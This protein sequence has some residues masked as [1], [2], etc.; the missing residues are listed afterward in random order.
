MLLLDNCSAHTISDEEKSKLPKRNL[1]FFLPLNMTRTYQPS[2]MS[3]I[4]ITEV[5]YK[6]TLIEQILY[7]FYIEGGYLRACAKIKKQNRGCK[8]ID[9]G[10]KNHF[11]GE[12]MIIKP[13]WE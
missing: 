8:G 2:D 11:L 4:D 1:I 10:G 12:M 7:I 3:M 9:F 13:I 6:V 5:G